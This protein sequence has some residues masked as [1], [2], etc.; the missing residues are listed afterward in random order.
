MTQES[1]RLLR[2]YV[3]LGNLYSI[4]LIF[5]FEVPRGDLVENAP[6]CIQRCFRGVPKV[7]F[8]FCGGPACENDFNQSADTMI[9]RLHDVT[10]EFL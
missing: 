10:N 2:L 3:F 1:K 8:F 5:S 7:R 9:V 4:F 6:M